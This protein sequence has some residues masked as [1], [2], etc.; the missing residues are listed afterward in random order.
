MDLSYQ[1]RP[2]NQDVSNISGVKGYPFL[3]NILEISTNPYQLVDRL[4]KEHGPVARFNMLNQPV[5]MLTGADINQAIYLD[6]LWLSQEFS[7]FRSFQ[8]TQ[9]RLLFALEFF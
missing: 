9:D 3:G 7:Q 6:R 1:H 4:Y 2:H 8:K 5:L